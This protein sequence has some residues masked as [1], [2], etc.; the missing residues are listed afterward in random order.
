MPR[1]R[2]SGRLGTVGRSRS[3]VGRVTAEWREVRPRR[4]SPSTV[5]R[6]IASPFWDRRGRRRP[7]KGRAKQWHKNIQ[8]TVRLHRAVACSVQGFLALRLRTSKHR[9]PSPR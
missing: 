5:Q 2:L 7:M 8:H 6:F 9:S 3:G 4:E 1:L